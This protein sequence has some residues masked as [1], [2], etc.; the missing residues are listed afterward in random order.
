MKGIEWLWRG[1]FKSRM[2]VLQEG[3]SEFCSAI[4]LSWFSC[5]ATATASGSVIYS[6]WQQIW[7]PDL[8]SPPIPLPFV[9]SSLKLYKVS[10]AFLCRY[11][12]VMSA[13]MSFSVDC[14]LPGPATR[15][16]TMAVFVVRYL[17]FNTKAV[18]KLLS[19]KWSDTKTCFVTFLLPLLFANQVTQ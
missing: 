4:H 18:N 19:D 7:C 15:V 12:F 14:C 10:A 5:P 6:G 1:I 13:V 9:L 3:S 11:C 17:P 8:G 2:S 16:Q